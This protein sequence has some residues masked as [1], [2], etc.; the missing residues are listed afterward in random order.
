MD[1]VSSL[2]ISLISD[3]DKAAGDEALGI[4]NEVISANPRAYTQVNIPKGTYLEPT[5]IILY[6]WTH[7]PPSLHISYNRTQ[8]RILGEREENY[9]FFLKFQSFDI[10]NIHSET[11]TLASRWVKPHQPHPPSVGGPQQK[12]KDYKLRVMNLIAEGGR[13]QETIDKFLSKVSLPLDHQLVVGG[14]FNCNLLLP[15]PKLTRLSATLNHFGLT[16]VSFDALPRISERF[17]RPQHFGD[18][19]I[20]H[21]EF[22]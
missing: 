17:F 21:L 2:A 15:S 10:Q 13:R 4:L 22:N 1:L 12:K 8:I 18:L 5:D 11:I 6:I 3:E 9:A 19:F 16:K 20:Y 7:L 14:D